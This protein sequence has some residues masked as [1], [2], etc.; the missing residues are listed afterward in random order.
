MWGVHYRAT[1]GPVREVICHCGMCRRV[2]GAAFPTFV[3]FPLASFVWTIGEPTRYCSSPEAEDGF[4]PSAAARSRCA[5]CARRPRLGVL[6]QP[7]PSRRCAPL[8]PRLDRE[9]SAIAAR[10]R[11]PPTLHPQQY[12][13][14]LACRRGRINTC[15]L[16][17]FLFSAIAF[18]AK[19]ETSV[20]GYIPFGGKIENKPLF[21]AASVL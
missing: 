11:R 10:R 2:S 6:G 5:I 19:V 14:P 9:P 18:T 20:V 1:A 4:P 8:R 13:G 15:L 12:R 16:H 21:V 7:R 3:H 17:E